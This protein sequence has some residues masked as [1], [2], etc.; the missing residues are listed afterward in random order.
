MSRRRNT[1]I[2]RALEHLCATMPEVTAAWVFTGDGFH[3]AGDHTGG[4]DADLLSALG[5]HATASLGRLTSELGLGPPSAITLGFDRGC[6]ALQPPSPD[7][8]VATLVE[9]R[10]RLGLAVLSSQLATAAMQGLA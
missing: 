4:Y 2:G 1:R 8:W 7:T 3:V 6:V 10:A 9:D 5:A